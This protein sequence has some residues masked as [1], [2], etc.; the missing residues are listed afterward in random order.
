MRLTRPLYECLPLIY[1]A[2]G[3]CAIFLS[4][5]DQ[6]GARAVA[7]LMIGLAA[8]VAA[9]TLYLRRRGYRE[10]RREYSGGDLV[11]PAPTREP[12]S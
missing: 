4:Y 10:M 12:R 9:L 8:L 2:V 3:A 7:T 1:A 5:V 6:P 11:A